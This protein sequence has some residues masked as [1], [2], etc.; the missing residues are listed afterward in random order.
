MGGRRRAPRLRLAVLVACAGCALLAG[1]AALGPGPRPV[2]GHGFADDHRPPAPARSPAGAHGSE[3]PIEPLGAGPQEPLRGTTPGARS[4]TGSAAVGDPVSDDDLPDDVVETQAP[5]PRP[6]VPTP[7]RAVHPALA[8]HLGWPAD[9]PRAG[10]LATWLERRED[11]APADLVSI[12]GAADAV[13]IA[14]GLV[15]L[16][17]HRSGIRP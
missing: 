11:G 3:A 14:E 9:D 15:A 2:P 8:A 6:A 17:A 4:A 12:S 10:R 7:R 13:L 16:D 5:P 1:A